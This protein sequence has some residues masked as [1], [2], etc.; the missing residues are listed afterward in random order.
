M[1]FLELLGKICSKGRFLKG[2][3]L[4]LHRW[5]KS[6]QAYDASNRRTEGEAV[7]PL[8]GLQTKWS[9]DGPTSTDE[10]M[11]WPEFK[12]FLKKC[13]RKLG[14]VLLSSYLPVHSLI[15]RQSFTDCIHAGEF[16]H[17]YNAVVVLKEVI[18]VFPIAAV[19]EVVGSS[20]DLEI[21]RLVQTE[22]RGDLKILAR[23]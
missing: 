2:I 14:K 11:K 16:M 15:R 21:Q 13:H 19:N 10:L 22:Q 6:Q 3:L 5:H 1:D 4:D 8:P 23:A 20:I 12:S 17:V 18:E 9:K 7:L